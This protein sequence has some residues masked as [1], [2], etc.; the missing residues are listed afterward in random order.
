MLAKMNDKFSHKFEEAWP[1]QILQRLRESFDMLN[2]VDWY[3]VFCAIY[4]AKMLNGGSVT[5]HVLYMIEMIERLDRLK[6]I[7]HE[8][9]GKDAILNSLPSSYLAFSVIIEWLSLQLITM[10]DKVNVDLRERPQ[11]K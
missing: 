11:T 1:D 2:D 10:F 6:C 4:N 8:Q 9:F 7:L 5:D 3:G